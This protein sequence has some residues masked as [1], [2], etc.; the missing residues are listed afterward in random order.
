VLYFSADD[1]TSGRELWK[2]DGTEAGTVLLKDVAPGSASSTPSAFTEVVTPSASYTFFVAD[3][4][5]HGAELWWTT[6]AEESTALAADIA[7]G[8]APS[9]PMDLTPAGGA[10]FYVAHDGT[11]LALYRTDVA[12]GPLTQKLDTPVPTSWDGEPESQQYLA[13][14]GETLYF[15][16]NT[17]TEMNGALYFIATDGQSGNELWKSDGTEAGTVLVK[18][19]VPGMFGAE[20]SH[21]THVNGRLFFSAHDGNSGFELW[22][23]DGTE[24]GT[25]LVGDIY[26]GWYSAEPRELTAVGDTLFFTANDGASAYELW[27]TVVTLDTTA[28]SVSLTQPVP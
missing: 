10:L 17:P 19:I 21:I 22:T 20:I 3:D 14:V 16:T 5:E 15:L 11:S 13:S 23:S 24:A 8:N 6:G 9:N 2:S 12:E 25:H 18:D 7:P 28:P 26:P 27:H 1:G 4:G